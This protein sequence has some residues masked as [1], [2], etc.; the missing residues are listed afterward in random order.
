[1]LQPVTT[2]RDNGKRTLK[3]VKVGAGQDRFGAAL[4]IAEWRF[5]CKISGKDTA[6]A[7]CVFDTI[8][9]AKGG[10]P[11]HVHHDQDEWFFVR[12]G[13]YVFKVG[14]ETFY[15]KAGDSLLGPR[16]VPHAFASLTEKSAMMILFQPAGDMEQL[17]FDVSQLAKSRQPTPEDWRTL[18]SWRGVDIIGPP[19]AFG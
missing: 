17:F 10:P 1:M 8:R 5:D 18:G 19:L 12:D 7:Y 3:A 6:G 16:K 4:Q 11:L 2:P 15:L 14:D 9:T 13:E